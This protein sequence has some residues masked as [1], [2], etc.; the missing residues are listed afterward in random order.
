MASKDPMAQY[1]PT[2]RVIQVDTRGAVILSE[3]SP[4]VSLPVLCA[5]RKLI[6][7][8]HQTRDS[9]GIYFPNHYEAV[10]H[11]ALDVSFRFCLFS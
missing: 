2:P 11:I 8:P 9:R 7:C 6:N 10:S 1:L 3:E 4:E 5:C